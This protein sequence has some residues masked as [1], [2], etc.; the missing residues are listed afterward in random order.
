[1][2]CWRKRWS[3]QDWRSGRFGYVFSRI[4][5]NLYY[6]LIRYGQTLSSDLYCPQLDHL[7]EAI[8]KKRPALA[9]KREL[10]WA[11][12]IVSDSPEL[13]W[14]AP[15]SPNLSPSLLIIFKITTSY[16]TKWCIFYKNWMNRIMLN[17]TFDL[18]Q[19]F[20]FTRSYTSICIS[21][22]DSTPHFL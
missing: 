2:N 7:R 11:T 18:M 9:N 10:R 16:R 3:N 21:K 17:K 22:I 8:G 13:S 14:E 15:Y 20:I 12:H 5:G 1:M 4:G 19:T 6:E